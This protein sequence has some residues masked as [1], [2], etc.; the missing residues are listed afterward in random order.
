MSRV[1]QPPSDT[2]RPTWL[3]GDRLRQ[4]HR[5]RLG[6]YGIPAHDQHEDDVVDRVTRWFLGREGEPTSHAHSFEEMGLC[7]DCDAAA[8]IDALD[9]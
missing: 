1:M 2:Q 3:D 8:L 9:E 6:A 7:V 5:E 4:M